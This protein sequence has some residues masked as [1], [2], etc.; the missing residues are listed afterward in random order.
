MP[1]NL[2]LNLGC[3]KNIRPDFINCDIQKYPGVNKVMDCSDLSVFIK[4][5]AELIFSHAFFEHLYLNQQIFFLNHC[6][7]ILNNKGVLILLGI[8][9]FDE[10]ARCYLEKRSMT[11]PFGGTFDLYQAYRLT[12]G[13]YEKNKTISIPQMHKTIFDK[14]AL[15][16]LFSLSKFKYFKIFSYN[17]YKEK[18]SLGLGVV[19]RKDSDFKPNEIK[20]ILTPFASIFDNLESEV[21]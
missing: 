14:K 11:S 17:F 15:E 7:R 2:K 8:P 12:H 6:F 21:I 20:I 5:S 1:N 9:N 19:A 4:D 18:Y 16:T 10:I 13:D 3:G